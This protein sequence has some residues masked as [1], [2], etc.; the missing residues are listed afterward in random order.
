MLHVGQ[1]VG[2][3]EDCYASGSRNH[4][5]TVA[6]SFAVVTC[7]D[8]ANRRGLNVGIAWRFIITLKPEPPVNGTRSTVQPVTQNR[9]G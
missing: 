2:T 7:H 8:N 1:N 3:T 9:E 5:A 4:H 6:S